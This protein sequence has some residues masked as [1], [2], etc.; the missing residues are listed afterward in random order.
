MVMSVSD[1]ISRAHD[2]DNI[3]AYTALAL[4]SHRSADHDADLVLGRGVED[5]DI[6]RRDDRDDAAVIRVQDLAF[7]TRIRALTGAGRRGEV[8]ERRGAKL[9]ARLRANCREGGT[10]R[11]SEEKEVG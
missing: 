8:G 6:R 7:R 10:R 3:C 9:D 5:L 11:E 2:G 4:S 1:H